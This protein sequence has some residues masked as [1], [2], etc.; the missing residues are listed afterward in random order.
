MVLGLAILIKFALYSST[1]L[2]IGLALH[3][4]IGI[5]DP[6]NPPRRLIALAVFIFVIAA[7]AKLLIANAQLAGSLNEAFSQRTF[8]WVWRAHRTQSI[9]FL[10]SAVLLLIACLTKQRP[11]IFVSALGLSAGFGLAGH[12]QALDQPALWSILVAIHLLVAGFWVAAPISLFPKSMVQNTHLIHRVERFSAVA[13]I[14]IPVLFVSGA[15]LLW[16][17]SGSLN[18]IFFTDYGRLLLSKLTLAMA[19][20]GIGAYNKTVVTMRLKSAG[21]GAEAALRKSLG[22]ETVLFT[23]VLIMIALATTIT[24]PAH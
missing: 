10:G 19:L 24:G 5:S 7:A 3:W 21:K 18:A 6:K 16:R 14:L 9:V 12:T 15:I 20:L 1:L 13:I 22:A 23:G 4:F 11:L 2:C 8:K 17:L